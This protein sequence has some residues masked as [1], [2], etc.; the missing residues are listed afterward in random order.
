MGRARSP[1]SGP[2]PGKGSLGAGTKGY[3]APERGGD[4]KKQIPSKKADV[5][6][7]GTTF[8]EASQG[9]FNDNSEFQ[10]LLAGL[11]QKNPEDR[12]YAEQAADHAFFG[13]LNTEYVEDEGP[14]DWSSV[15]NS[16]EAEERINLAKELVQGL[17]E[18]RRQACKTNITTGT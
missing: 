5:W 14:I 9:L 13:Q 17:E 11:L 8:K 2:P 7:L 6:A 3:W 12:P 18:R 10:N 1:T 4:G 16:R 15:L